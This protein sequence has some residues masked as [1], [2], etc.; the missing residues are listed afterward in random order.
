M[1]ASGPCGRLIERRIVDYLRAPDNRRRSSLP[2]AGGD[3][4]NRPASL[5]SNFPLGLGLARKNKRVVAAF[6]S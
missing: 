5:S 2:M 6:I 1:G 4:L 3:F